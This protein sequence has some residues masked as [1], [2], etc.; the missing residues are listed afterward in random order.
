[1]GQKGNTTEEA[2]G[3]SLK[4][5][6]LKMPFEKITIRDITEE[7]GL[8]RPTFYNH[9]K[10]KYDLLEWIFT[11][12]IIQPAEA[13]IESNMMEEAVRLMLRRMEMDLDF[14]RKAVRIQGQ[15]SFQDIIF[16]AFRDI[17]KRVLE[18]KMKGKHMANR[19]L[20]PD[21]IAEYYAAVS[22]FVIIRW[23]KTEW[24]V[25]T[26]EVAQAYTMLVAEPLDEMIR[27]LYSHT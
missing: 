7:A 20:T 17:M 19:L 12:E 27:E 26:Q 16:Q 1:M 11:E 25:T 2:L 9:F 23:I 22:S 6:I 3:Y 14:Y 5:L 13:L 8:M 21:S 15:N 10:D 24:E 4:K 18:S